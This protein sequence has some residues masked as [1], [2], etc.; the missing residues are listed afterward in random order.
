MI[1]AVEPPSVAI[2][3]KPP[4]KVLIGQM[5]EGAT[6]NYTF[7]LDSK[8]KTEGKRQ[9]NERRRAISS[10]LVIRVCRE[11]RL[12]IASIHPHK[13]AV[14]GRQSRAHN[15]TGSCTKVK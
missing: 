12:S 1:A 10:Y 15:N 6:R 7:T 13:S 2:D 9:M 11:W 5:R 3:E 14:L 8:Q 4:H